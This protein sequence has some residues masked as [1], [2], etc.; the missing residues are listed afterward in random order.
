[1]TEKTRILA[2]NLKVE[3]VK[4]ILGNERIEGNSYEMDNKFTLDTTTEAVDIIS[5]MLLILV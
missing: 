4:K 1:M 3:R 2:K 5:S